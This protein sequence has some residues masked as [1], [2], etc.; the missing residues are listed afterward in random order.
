MWCNRLMFAML[1]M[2]AAANA[3]AAEKPPVVKD[4]EAYHFETFQFSDAPRQVVG[5][6]YRAG[7]V[8]AA[9][10]LGGVG[11][12]TVALDSRGQFTRQAIANSYRPVGGV[13]P[14]CGFTIHTESEGRVVEQPL[15]KLV[16]SY[17]GH[18]PMTD[19]EGGHA[20]MPLILQLR[21]MSPF[22]LGDAR[23]SA[24]P[25]AMFRFRVENPG[26]KPVKVTITFRW[27]TPAS[28]AP[29]KP[30]DVMVRRTQ[31]EDGADAI[32]VTREDPADHAGCTVAA[33]KA[34]GVA[35]GCPAAPTGKSSPEVIS[36]AAA[37]G[38]PAHGRQEFR[39][40]LAWYYPEARSSSREFVGHQ[41]GNWFDGSPSVAK[42]VISQ[43]DSL[44][45][46]TGQWQEQIYDDPKLPGWLKDQLVN[47]LYALARNTSWIKDG[48]FSQSESFTGCPITETIVCRFYGST[49]LAMFFPELE[50]NTMRQFIRHQRADGAI[51]FAF[52]FGENWD[53]P[54]TTCRRFSTAASSC[55]WRGATTPGGR[56]RPGRMKSTP[57]S[58]KR[59]PM[60]APWTPTGTG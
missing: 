50:K 49:P 29:P 12:G 13:M 1:W 24:T 19:I 44:A 48:R 41:Y 4:N 58:R 36:V 56:T 11:T 38:L 39:F 57:P 54:P 42:L 33:L 45:R 26:G 10:P 27:D 23:A 43:W 25:A 17:L 30:G 52:G 21:A 28:P 9:M 5:V 15:S 2:T 31:R 8:R 37:A 40:V 18:F 16:Q 51:P 35:A 20:E 7:D 55:C 22:I 46:R 32:A 53:A 60:P 14:G 6:K 59:S 47:S 34:A 3:F